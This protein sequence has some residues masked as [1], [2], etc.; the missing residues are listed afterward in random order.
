MLTTC[1]DTSS[2]HAN[3]IASTYGGIMKKI[4]YALIAAFTMGTLLAGCDSGNDVSALVPPPPPTELVW[5]EAAW[6]EVD[7]Q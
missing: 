7:W 6:D 5:D 3:L 2:T 4:G 1:V